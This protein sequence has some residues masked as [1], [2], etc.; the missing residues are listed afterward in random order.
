MYS[1][2]MAFSKIYTVTQTHLQS[3]IITV[4][5]D[6]SKGLH[7]FSIV[8]LADKTVDE[9]KERCSLALKHTKKR[10]PRASNEKIL[11]SLAPAHIRKTGTVFDVAISIAYLCASEQIKCDVSKTIFLGEL[12]LDGEVKRVRGVIPMIQKAI[13]EGYEEI[14][15]LRRREGP[16]LGRLRGRRSEPRAPFPRDGERIHKDRNK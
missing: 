1:S 16:R 11:I 5:A 8:G 6:V 15:P 2:R 9:A 4:E 7:H 10:S 3:E 14:I 12:S 13:Q